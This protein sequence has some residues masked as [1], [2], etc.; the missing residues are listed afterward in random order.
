MFIVCPLFLVPPIGETR[1]PPGRFRTASCGSFQA[2][3]GQ[4][5]SSESV[6]F[7][8]IPTISLKNPVI[9]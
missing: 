5:G 8:K 3:S 4:R 9:S 7:V 1:K 6:N 2:G